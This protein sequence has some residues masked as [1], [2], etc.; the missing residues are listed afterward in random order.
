MEVE[1]LEREEF[2]KVLIANGITP[3]AKEVEGIDIVAEFTAP[4]V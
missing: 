1:T 4:T 3:K 2:E